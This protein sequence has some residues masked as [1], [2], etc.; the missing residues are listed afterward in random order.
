MSEPQPFVPPSDGGRILSREDGIDVP[1]RPIIPYILG[2]GIGV[3]VTPATRTVLDAATE[4]AYGGGKSIAW[5]EVLAGEKAKELTGQWLPG[6]TLD[7]FRDYHVGIKGPLTTPIGGGIRSLNVAIRQTLDLY[8]NVRPV[9]WIP[10]IPS[11]V[12]EPAAMDMILFREATEDVYAGIEWRAGSP[13]AVTVLEFLRDKLGVPLDNVDATGVG[14][15]PISAFRTKRLVRKAIRHAV[16][17]GRQSVTLVHKGNIMK[18][19]EGAFRDW[20]YE[21]AAQEFADE[22]VSEADL[23]DA[24]GGK[25][26]QGKVV[27]NDRIADNMLQQLLTRTSDYSVLALPNLNGDYL[28][29]AAAAQVGGLGIAHGA[30]MGDTVAVFEAVHGTAPKYAGQDKVNPT[31]LILSGV[32]MLE[33]LG[34]DDAAQLVR[35]AVAQTVSD[36]VLTYDLARQVGGATEV[37]CSAFA[38]AIVERM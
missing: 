10:G 20:G 37:S 32:M 17:R 8:A 24:H 26:P 27:V 36:R 35:D 16:Q 11:P 28:S 18:Y 15:K 5:M 9:Y 30:N 22:T 21:V 29:D 34:W 33:H 19:T 3:D 14:V 23:W 13:E 1:A 38:A 7:A 2:D 25:V 12:K 6:D 31:A 4:K